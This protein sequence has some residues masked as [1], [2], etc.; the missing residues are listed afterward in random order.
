[1]PITKNMNDIHRIRVL[2]VF[3]L[4]NKVAITYK[5]DNINTTSRFHDFSIKVSTTSDMTSII[6]QFDITQIDYNDLNLNNIINQSIRTIIIEGLEI[7]TA[8]DLYLQL[9]NNSSDIKHINF[10][11]LST[12][13]Q[14]PSISCYT[15]DVLLFE[16]YKGSYGSYKSLSLKWDFSKP[17]WRRLSRI[18]NDDNIDLEI[19]FKTNFQLD[20]PDWTN[21]LRDTSCVHAINT[22]QSN[23]LPEYSISSKDTI[24]FINLPFSAISYYYANE[25]TDWGSLFSSGTTFVNNREKTLK[26]LNSYSQTTSILDSEKF[27][28]HLNDSNAVYICTDI[29]GFYTLDGGI[30]WINDA[31]TLGLPIQKIITVKG[32]H[33]FIVYLFN[34]PHASNIKIVSIDRPSGAYYGVYDITDTNLLSGNVLDIQLIPGGSASSPSFQ[35]L[36]DEYGNGVPSKLK[37]ISHSFGEVTPSRRVAFKEEYS[38]NISD[39]PSNIEILGESLPTFDPKLINYNK[40]Q[41]IQNLFTFTEECGLDGLYNTKNIVMVD[42]SN[43]IKAFNFN[44]E[45]SEISGFNNIVLEGAGSTVVIRP[46]DSISEL[47]AYRPGDVQKIELTTAVES[48]SGG[49]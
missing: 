46:R 12:P 41:M 16:P 7:G 8:Y 1:M 45:T 42:G 25:N 30:T 32:E 6:A 49:E 18:M 3:P 26:L 28:N 4:C 29:G 24:N 23:F 9:S 22:S 5:I 33:G 20:D 38:F 43:I 35:V 10:T 40:L 31:Q 34:T 37:S 39:I 11:T 15:T 47:I 19:N 36:I 13:Y 27:I 2:D 14:L 48:Q 21:K 17:E 44:S